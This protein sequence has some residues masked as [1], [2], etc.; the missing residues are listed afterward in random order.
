[1]IPEHQPPKWILRNRE[2][3]LHD[4]VLVMGILNV[5]PDSFSDA[6]RYFGTDEAVARALSIEQ[7]G[8]DLLDIGG[9][10]SRPGSQ[11]V[12]LQE[13]LDRVIPVLSRLAGRLRIPIS[14]DTTKAEVARR[15][16]DLGAEVINDVSALN[17]DPHM[18]EVI[19]QYGAGL[20][21]MHMQGVPATMQENPF[22]TDVVDE[23]TEF[24]RQRT[25]VAVGAGI[26]PKRIALDPGI[27]F[28]KRLQ[29]NL[30]LLGKLSSFRVLGHPIVVG[31]SRKG[32]L[33]TLLDRQ[34]WERE[35]GTAAAIACSVLNGADVVRVHSVA[36]MRDVVRV[37]HAIRT[38]VDTTGSCKALGT[39]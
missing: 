20:I 6:G 11:P 34:V 27:G 7:E 15:S 8:A 31:P 28:G 2:L 24:F 12:S 26:D 1:V 32:F 33:G 14:V 35:W 3:P 39:A 22:Y 37:S 5:T 17:H 23:L 9:E 30:T 10:S 18:A 4:R 36:E 19:A 29:D 21:V 25:K 38:A 13:E 16:L